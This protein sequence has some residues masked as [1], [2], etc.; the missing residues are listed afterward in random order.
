MTQSHF[1]FYPQSID[2]VLQVSPI[3]YVWLFFRFKKWIPD[4][5]R[6]LDF[7]DFDMNFGVQR[8]G[9]SRIY[10]IVFEA[11]DF[12]RLPHFLFC[13]IYLLFSWLL[14]SGLDPK[15][16]DFKACC[17]LHTERHIG[18]SATISFIYVA[19]DFK[20]RHWP[21]VG[22]EPPSLCFEVSC[23]T[24][25]QTSKGNIGQN[26]DLN[27]TFF[28]FVLLALAS[29]WTWTTNLGAQSQFVYWAE[30]Y[31]AAQT[32]ALTVSWG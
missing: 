11:S 13:R 21:S 29:K 4:K 19:S 8:K 28:V 9:Q 26:G 27:Q 3:D 30:N 16:L 24:E 23:D 25:G 12:K 22:L 7:F 18:L 20:R 17:R 2:S 15:I 31:P 14:N 32:S 5:S 1:S 6:L 10:F